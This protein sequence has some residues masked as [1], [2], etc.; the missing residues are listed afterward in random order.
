MAMTLRLNKELESALREIAVAEDRPIHAV[1]VSAI[2][3]YVARRREQEFAD[4]AGEVM[5]R[6]A[7]LLDRLAQ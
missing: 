5:Q 6:H 2:D 7:A 1:V 4:L 3:E